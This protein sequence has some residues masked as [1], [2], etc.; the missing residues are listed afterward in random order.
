MDKNI[1]KMEDLKAKL[2]IGVHQIRVYLNDGR[3]KGRKVRNKWFVQPNDFQE[4]K[5]A[6]GF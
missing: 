2:P 6:Y 3:L 4:F 5:Q 1:L